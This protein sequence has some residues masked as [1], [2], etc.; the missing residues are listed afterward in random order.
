MEKGFAKFKFENESD[1]KINLCLLPGIARHITTL[2]RLGFKADAIA[3]DSALVKVSGYDGWE[4]ADFIKIVRAVRIDVKLLVIQNCTADNTLFDESIVIGRT[5][6]ATESTV[7]R[8]DL[9]PYLDVKAFDRT[10]ITIP[11]QEPLKEHPLYLD[12]ITYMAMTLPPKASVIITF[13][14]NINY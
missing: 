3:E 9:Q 11:F 1:Q 8:I 6:T 7:Q 14:Y 12:A 10:K 5:I 2:E 13:V 4:W